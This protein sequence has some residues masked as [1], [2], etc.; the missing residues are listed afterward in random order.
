MLGGL[1]ESSVA[2]C[3]A[4]VQPQAGA[5]LDS[6]PGHPSPLAAHRSRLA[7]PGVGFGY[8]H[9]MVRAKGPGDMRRG[10]RFG[11]VQARWSAIRYR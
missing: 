1:S 7:R 10:K 6:L 11:L 4:T 5:P 9:T 2:G 3:L 8:V